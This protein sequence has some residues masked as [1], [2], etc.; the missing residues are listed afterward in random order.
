MAGRGT[1]ER[2]MAAVY[3]INLFLMALDARDAIRCPRSIYIFTRLF[4]SLV[5]GCGI[6]FVDL[7]SRTVGYKFVIRDLAV[8]EAYFLS[9]YAL[10]RIGSALIRFLSL[11]VQRFLLPRRHGRAGIAESPFAL[12]GAQALAMLSILSLTV[13]VGINGFSF[14]SSSYTQRYTDAAG[15]GLI[16]LFFPAALP[17]AAYILTKA[18]SRI[19]FASA[20]LILLLYNLVIFFVLHGYRQILIGSTLLVVMIALS[21]NFIGARHVALAG[22]TLPLL[23]IGLSFLRYSGESA[24]PFVSSLEAAMYYI[25]GDI[26]PVDAPLRIMQYCSYSD[27]PGPSVVMNHLYKFVPRQIWPD[28]PAILM[29]SAG[30]YTQAIIGYGR[31]LTLSATI[32]G[33]AILLDNLAFFVILMVLTG[34]V[35][36]L[37]SEISDSTAGTLIYYVL[38]SNLYMGFFIVREGLAEGV[39]RI[40]VI[41]VYYIIGLFCA[42][43]VDFGAS[44]MRGR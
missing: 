38:I 20:A 37:L 16:I 27:C 23:S 39:N 18:P 12:R 5:I 8:L 15:M 34:G 31:F 7:M 28:K 30:Y 36:R 25:Q 44:L 42:Y 9:G 4:Y 24:S 13:Y 17:Y 41:V 3:F 22:V 1:V 33:E 21:R 2:M 26:F 11:A 6:L 10:I 43:F 14:G 32:L 40:I 29:D 35:T 19:S